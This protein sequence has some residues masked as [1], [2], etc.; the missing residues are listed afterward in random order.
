[1]IEKH[2]KQ[3]MGFAKPTVDT[4][5][6]TLTFN[7]VKDKIIEKAK[8]RIEFDVFKKAQ[9]TFGVKEARYEKEIEDLIKKNQNFKEKILNL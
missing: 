4:G 1:M 5:S 9:A 7:R 2:V 3:Q 6:Q 8:V